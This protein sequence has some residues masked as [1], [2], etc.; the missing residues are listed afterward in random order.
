MRSL[1]HR[2]FLLASLF[3]A[4][5]SIAGCSS[6]PEALPNGQDG[7]RRDERPHG[8]EGSGKMEG[9]TPKMEPGKMEGDMPKM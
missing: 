9:D 2:T 7:A 8:K 3:L 1:S 4:C 6:E 5:G